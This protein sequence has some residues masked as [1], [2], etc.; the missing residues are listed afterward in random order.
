MSMR[1]EYLTKNCGTI[2]WPGNPIHGKIVII[3]TVTKKDK[4]GA[5]G[6]SESWYY[7]NEGDSKILN[8]DDFV[9][10]YKTPSQL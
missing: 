8:G 5:I 9:A 4:R 2:V 7:L 3:E 1:K 10:Y 6:K